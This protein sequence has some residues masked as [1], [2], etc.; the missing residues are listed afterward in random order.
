[1][2]V[3][4]AAMSIVLIENDTNAGWFDMCYHNRCMNE[5]NGIYLPVV[6]RSVNASWHSINPKH[7]I[8]Q[9]MQAKYRKQ[10]RKHRTLEPPRT[11]LEKLLNQRRSKK[12]GVGTERDRAQHAAC[13][14]RQW[15]K[16]AKGWE[17]WGWGTVP[18]N[19]LLKLLACI[20]VHACMRTYHCHLRHRQHDLL[21]VWYELAN[22]LTWVCG[23]M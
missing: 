17:S 15:T 7:C 6:R 9:S 21:L 5:L 19:A 2:H 1:M 16:G 3:H 8:C 11:I 12:T 10:L 20:H 23:C 18:I 13:L 14:Q 4:V 22:R